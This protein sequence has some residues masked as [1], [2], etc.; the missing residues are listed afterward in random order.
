MSY[1]GMGLSVLYVW[2]YGTP[3]LQHLQNHMSKE[4]KGNQPERQLAALAKQALRTRTSAYI[5]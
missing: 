5:I 3:L 1:Y 2:M 4:N